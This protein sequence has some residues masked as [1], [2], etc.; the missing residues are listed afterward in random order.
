MTET[1]SPQR[2][3]IPSGPSRLRVERLT[4]QF[5][6]IRALNEVSLT[7]SPKE[8][9]G[10]IGPNGSGKTTLINVVTGFLAPT[11]GQVFKGNTEITGLAPHQIGLLGIARTFQTIRLFPNLTVFENTMVS[12]VALKGGL[13]RADERGPQERLSQLGIEHLAHRLAYSLPYGDQRRVEIARALGLDPQFLLLDEPA[14]GM[15]DQ[16]AEELMER[17][18]ALRE[19]RGCG[20]LVVD[21]DLRFI[22]RVSDRVVVLNEGAIIADGVP[23]VV[24]S[25]PAVVEAYVGKERK[26]TRENVE[27]DLPGQQ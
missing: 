16:E 20:I 10:L 17:I 13:L 1:G 19:N 4:K 26:R 6:G 25:E 3:P 18:L 15:N 2:N 27:Q 14:A 12:E 21:H 23:A 11:Q 5:G 8:I 22:M 7:L 9:L 24:A